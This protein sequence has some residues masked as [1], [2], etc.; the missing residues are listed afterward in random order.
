MSVPDISSVLSRV[1]H[2]LLVNGGFVQSPGLLRGKMGIALFLFHYGRFSGRE[3]FAAAASELMEDILSQTDQGSPVDYAEG[4]AGFGTAVE[5][6]IREQFIE[7]ESGS[8]LSAVDEKVYHH[9]IHHTP[10]L[11]WTDCGIPGLGRYFAARKMEE[12]LSRTVDLLD[13]SFSSYPV[14]SGVLD[15][16]AS[17]Y[18]L[19][20]NAG[21]AR[22]Y[23]LYAADRMETMLRE[24]AF[25]G[26]FPDHFCPSE[27]SLSLLRA[28]RKTG[29]TELAGTAS[30]VLE[31]FGS[32]QTSPASSGQGLQAG[33][34]RTAL[35]CHLL[36][37]EVPGA[38]YDRKSAS[39]L[40]QALSEAPG[41]LAGIPVA[42]PRG[43]PEMGLAQGYAGAGMALLTLSGACSPEWTELLTS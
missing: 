6:L 17:A 1:A 41:A 33:A 19:N 8:V 28:A 5:Y 10:E 32:E 29:L 4:L 42:A 24:D 43:I 26:K 35:T 3:A 40:E 16:L 30:W 23:L 34:L 11:L 37:R 38:G 27:M 9:L 15:V 21:K 14:L 20:V 39:W 13:K 25:F 31:R 18:T 36:H 2:V 12:A 7:P 22:H